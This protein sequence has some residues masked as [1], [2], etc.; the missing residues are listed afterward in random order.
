MTVENHNSPSNLNQ[1]LLSP[2]QILLS[3][4]QLRLSECKKQ[5]AFALMH[6]DTFGADLW[7]MRIHNYKIF[8]N[9][10]IVIINKS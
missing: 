7:N 8:I 2:T 5:L 1:S 10:L 4:Y 9:E 6:S 3:K